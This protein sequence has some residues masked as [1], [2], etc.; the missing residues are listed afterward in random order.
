[1]QKNMKCLRC[2]NPMEKGNTLGTPGGITI[3][4]QGD[5]VGDK[6]IPFYCK[7]CGYI[8][9]YNERFLNNPE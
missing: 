5:F 2:G 1:M 6:I 7:H 9:L 3:L 8:E 4:K